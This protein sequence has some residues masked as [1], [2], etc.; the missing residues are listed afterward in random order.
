VVDPREIDR[1]LKDMQ[2]R[3]HQS[4]QSHMSIWT[5]RGPVSQNHGYGLDYEPLA[6]TTIYADHDSLLPSSL[7]IKPPNVVVVTGVDK[8]VNVLPI[9]KFRDIIRDGD[10]DHLSQATTIVSIV[11]PTC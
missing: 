4:H 2:Q 3:C 10:S 6:V 8:V 11:M 7:K 9:P 1:Q 5:S